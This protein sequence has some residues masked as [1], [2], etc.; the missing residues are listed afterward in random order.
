MTG[1]DFRP[2][3]DYLAK[4]S[5]AKKARNK[6]YALEML[7]TH[8]VTYESKNSATHLIVSGEV[9]VDYWPTTGKWIARDT[10]KTSARGIKS[11]LAF[12]KPL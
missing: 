11:L 3:K 8:H 1:E 9:I 10:R 5:K 7:D 6:H 12:L 4:H 2:L